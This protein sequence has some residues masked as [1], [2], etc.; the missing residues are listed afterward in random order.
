M[1]LYESIALKV[2][3]N[4]HI[5]KFDTE[6]PYKRCV[7]NIM[8]MRKVGKT[9]TVCDNKLTNYDRIKLLNDG[10]EVNQLFY[11]W[12]YE[13]DLWDPVTKNCTGFSIKWTNAHK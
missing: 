1:T 12:K 2:S 4:S 9:E 6:T 7:N 11:P 13:K 10:Y 8:K 3:N 5:Q